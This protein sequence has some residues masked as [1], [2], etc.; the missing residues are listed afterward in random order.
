[1]HAALLAILVPAFVSVLTTAA[2]PAPVNELDR[3]T[4]DAVAD[5]I[6]AQPQR[7]QRGIASIEA[8]ADAG[9]IVDILTTRTPDPKATVDPPARTKAVARTAQPA[10]RRAHR[11]YADDFDA[12]DFD[13]DDF[14][15]DDFDADDF[16]TDDF[17]PMDPGYGGVTPPA[18][19]NGGDNFWAQRYGRGNSDGDSGYVCVDGACATYGM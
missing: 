15:A 16:D 4:V 1:M 19:G 18:A 12:D 17:E 3:G 14:D 7:S 8:P 9:Q 2:T 13:A 6:A 11:P 10:P 5:A